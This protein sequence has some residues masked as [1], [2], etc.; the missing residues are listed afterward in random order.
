MERR[1]F[2]KGAVVV[3]AA[4]AAAGLSSCSSATTSPTSD[5]GTDT[6]ESQN[7]E[8]VPGEKLDC[9]VC[10]YGTGISGLSAIVQA[11]Q[12]GAKVIALEASP[13]A[14]GNGVSVEGSFAHGSPLQQEQGIEFDFGT[15][16]VQ[17]N[18]CDSVPRGRKALARP[19]RQVRR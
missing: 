9:D 8:I 15:L 3:G 7:E 17:E 6:V 19:L 1:D 13:N 18:G 14:G 16:I 4:A 12:L 10:V 5:A 11:A 2:L